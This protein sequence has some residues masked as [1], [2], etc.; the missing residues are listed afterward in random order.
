MPAFDSGLLD[1]VRVYST[2]LSAAD[3]A[4]VFVNPGSTN[5]I[6]NASGGHILIAHY[7][8]DNSGNEGSDS[9]GQGNDINC[10]SSWGPGEL[11]STDAIAGGGALD[12]LG[13]TSLTP[14]GQAF[15][16]WTNTL[17]GSFTVSAWINTTTVVGSDGDNLNDYSGQS[18]VYADNN[19][20]GA[21]PIALTGTKAAFRTTDPESNDDTLHSLQSVTTGNYV[22]IVATRDQA[23]GEKELYINGKLDSSDIAS[24]N[25]L[26]GAQYV[27]IGGES[28]SA[29]QGLVDDVQIYSG[30]LSANDVASLFSNPGTSVPDI[31]TNSAQ[32]NAALG[33]ANL[34]WATS[35]DTSWFVET[36][37]TYNGASAAVQS[38]SVINSQSSRLLTTVTGP[39]TLTFYWSSIANDSNNGF[40]YE[41]YFDDPFTGD[42]AD[43]YGDN[44]WQQF[45]VSIPSGQHTLGWV[46]YP[47][48]DTDPT[49]AGFLDQVNLVLATDMLVTR[50]A[51]LSLKIFWSDVVNQW[52]DPNGNAVTLASINLVTTNAVTVST[53]GLLILYPASAPNVAD[54]ISYT[55][56]DSLGTTT[57]GYIN[58]VVNSSVTATNSITGITQ[59]GSSSTTVT[60]FGIPGYSYILERATN[61]APAIWV[62]I[63]TT[64][65]GVNGIIT[66]TDSFT[67]L[68]NVAPASAFY[69]LKWQP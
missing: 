64:A 15:T 53:N 12:F 19:N 63:T 30:V 45:S 54:Q 14:C 24:T 52:S 11:F 3:V 68:G 59:N 13:G 27:S 49:H 21:T 46:V 28:G 40:D 48:G 32:F 44:D 34:S 22:H 47:N 26:T 50:T 58:I 1:D 37:N 2:E 55:I 8:F 62:D 60:A 65:A 35:G 18:V 9:S 5:L 42:Q 61:L 25:F 6:G 51:G 29:Y 4:N 66:A 31:S 41:F 20:L 17:A 10:S 38:G 23:T 56:S 69:R 36:D 39:G 7:T 33:T 16:S 67:D 57:T 43:L